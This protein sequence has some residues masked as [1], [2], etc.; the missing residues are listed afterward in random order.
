M[1]LLYLG[2]VTV[3]ACSGCALTKGTGQ[4]DLTGVCEALVQGSMS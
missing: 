1:Y 2:R 4:E 3:S